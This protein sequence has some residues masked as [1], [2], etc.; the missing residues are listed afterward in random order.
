MRGILLL[1]A[2]LALWSQ[3]IDSLAPP[4]TKSPLAVATTRAC[5]SSNRQDI[6]CFVEPNNA[7]P[8]MALPNSI[9]ERTAALDSNN[10][11]D[12]EEERDASRRLLM[13]SLIGVC[14]L[15]GVEGAQ[16]MDTTNSKNNNNYYLEPTK[17]TSAT[18]SSSSISSTN[19]LISDAA[20]V[21][22]APVDWSAIA[23]KASKKALGGGKAGASAAVVQVFSLMW[24]RTSMNYQVRAFKKFFF[25]TWLY[26]YADNPSMI[27]FTFELWNTK[28]RFYKN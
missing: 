17:T 16:A 4:T 7:T 2:P 22:A 19:V 5:S 18:S 3:G 13:T 25:M 1:F 6:S 11:D 8:I 15:T 28:R 9:N 12:M 21:A 26:S 23:Q 20:A 24:L 27:G 10:E 14:L